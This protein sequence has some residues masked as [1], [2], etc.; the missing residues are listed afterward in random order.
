MK[1]GGERR[2]VIIKELEKK[3]KENKGVV[4][5]HVGREFR[6]HVE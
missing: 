1:G 5:W 4:L 6:I 2:K 3:G